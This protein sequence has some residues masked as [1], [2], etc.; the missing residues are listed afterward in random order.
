VGCPRIVYTDLDPSFCQAIEEDQLARPEPSSRTLGP[1]IAGHP[2]HGLYH[3]ESPEHQLDDLERTVWL[4]SMLGHR[5][6]LAPR[7]IVDTGCYVR[8]FTPRI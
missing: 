3:L 1:A 2:P 8:T 7:R 6:D 4:P 5:G